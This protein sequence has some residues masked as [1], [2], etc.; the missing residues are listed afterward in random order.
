MLKTSADAMHA[1]VRQG[2]E[3]LAGHFDAWLALLESGRRT[4]A[5]LVHA[6]PEE[7]AFTTNTSTALSLVAAA[8]RWQPGDRVLYPADEFPSNRFVWD[9]LAD[10]E[11]S[12]EAVE[13]DPD[14]DFADQLATMDL[15]SVRLVALSAVSYHDGRCL[16]VAK[17]TELCHAHDILVAVD[18]IQA[19][20]A[21]PVDVRKWG[22]DFL[23]C[24]GQKWLLGP[25]GSGFLYV[26]R[27]RVAELR[28]PLVGWASSRSAGDFDAPVLE[29]VDGARR[30][31]PGLPDIAAIAGLTASIETLA[32]VGWSH[33]FDRIRNTADRLTTGLLAAGFHPL[34]SAP[35]SGTSGI[36]AVELADDAQA[37]A[38]EAACADRRI[39]ITHRLRELRISVHS[40]TIDTD[41]DA[42]LAT[43]Q[44]HHQDTTRSSAA[45]EPHQPPGS[46]TSPAATNGTPPQAGASWKR[47]LVTGGSRGLGE[48]IAR[49]LA[50][51]GCD[52]TLVGRDRLRT[53][54]V[55]NRIRQEFHVAVD[56]VSLDLS[57]RSAV[58]Q[59]LSESPLP[60][61]DVLINNAAVA[62]A[63]MFTHSDPQRLR[64]ALETN[65]FAP[66]LLTQ[67]LLPGMLE[68]GR[69][70]VLNVVT[71]GAR[72]ALPLFSEYAASKGALWA[73]SESLQR[74]LAGT[75][76]TV[77]TFV[78]PHM[79]TATRRR[80]GRKALSYFRLDKTVA[81]AAS[82]AHVGEKAV[83]A[84]AAGRATV[85]PFNTRLQSALNALFPGL[86]TKR[87]QHS[88]RG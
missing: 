68:R 13:P 6:S 27:D 16:D 8:V 82:A 40:T 47:A 17:V 44:E 85:V 39:V 80:L 77:T 42:L 72:C 38:I 69:G 28:V 73:F 5:D 46:I 53:E 32:Q 58:E 31:E 22:C 84:L 34:R 23:A 21:V 41:V 76:V 79:E 4:V 1:V 83:A 2:L 66:A 36:V 25:V 20:G 26:A 37:Q 50:Q 60:A 12:A 45:V 67:K 18:G 7:I 3:P 88:W 59:W 81:P 9:N 70:A 10:L 43:L 11:V 61:Y 51:R 19:V 33:I 62:E 57:D 86:V 54:A 71:S 74:E 14:M 35:S 87:I 24:G 55:A 63:E 15:S 56:A 30:F 29:F 64:D 78:P 48:G 52:V 75:G 65:F 49:A